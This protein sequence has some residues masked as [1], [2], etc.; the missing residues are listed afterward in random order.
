[1]DLK[2]NLISISSTINIFFHTSFSIK[3]KFMSKNNFIRWEQTKM[4]INKMILPSYTELSKKYFAFIN[5]SDFSP[6]CIAYMLRDL[7]DEIMTSYPALKGITFDL[8]I[9]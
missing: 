8:K 6:K 3:K 5:K 1:M 4:Q 2:N 7:P 9:F